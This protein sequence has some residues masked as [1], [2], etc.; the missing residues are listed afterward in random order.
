MKKQLLLFAMILLPLVASAEAV[1]I[2]GLYYYLIQNGKYAVVANSTSYRTKTSVKIPETVKYDGIT[3]DVTTIGEDAFKS[4]V[5]L[6]EIEIGKKVSVIEKN[7]FQDCSELNSLYIPGNVKRIESYAFSNLFHVPIITIENGIE[8]IGTGAFSFC[9]S[10]LEIQIPNSVSE[11]KSSA[12]ASCQKLQKAILSEKITKISSSL[13]DYCPKLETVVI[14]SLVKEIESDVFKSCSALRDIYL[15]AKEVPS[16]NIYYSIFDKYAIYDI[17]LHVPASSVN[18]YKEATPW[19]D[20]KNIVA[21]EDADP[22]PTN[23]KLRESS[24]KKDNS[25]YDLNGHQVKQMKKGVY[26]SKGKKILVK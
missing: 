19:K 18:L 20:C 14:G 5:K 22:S 23:I 13:F 3:Y 4:C 16:V 2:D 15:Y 10:I 11:I 1:L 17:T 8:Y 12:F 24:I 25:I 26:I 21:L 7:A 9:S 6:K